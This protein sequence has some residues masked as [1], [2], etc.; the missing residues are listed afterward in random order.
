V[1]TVE[2]RGLEIVELRERGLT[3]REVGVIVGLSRSRACEI[4]GMLRPRPDDPELEVV[5][6]DEPMVLPGGAMV[7]CVPAVRGLGCSRCPYLS[8]CNQAVR[9][10]D[11]IACE[12]PLQ[13]EMHA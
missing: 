12:S 1:K 9:R 4:Y 5:E 3:F 10:G 6:L 7:W 13:K 2:A 11:F 8:L